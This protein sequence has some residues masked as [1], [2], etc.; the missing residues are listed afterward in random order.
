MR[1]ADERAV[2]GVWAAEGAVD[3]IVRCDEQEDGRQG[4]VR[5]PLGQGS[6]RR[7]GEFNRNLNDFRHNFQM[8]TSICKRVVTAR[9]LRP[10]TT[11][12]TI[13]SPPL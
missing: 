9:Q 6:C 5:R 4:G 11:T 2:G 3:A 13:S 12:T 7:G 1:D 8:L 10:S